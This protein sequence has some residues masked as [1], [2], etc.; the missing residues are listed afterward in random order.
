MVKHSIQPEISAWMKL[1]GWHIKPGGKKA[2]FGQ[3]YHGHI[4]LGQ[5]KMMDIPELPV[6]A[7]SQFPEALHPDRIICRG[8]AYACFL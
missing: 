8:K 3:S 7:H 2:S 6:P 4:A 1:H 5:I